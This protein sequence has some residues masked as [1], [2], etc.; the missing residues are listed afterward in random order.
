[1][2]PEQY[3]IKNT[4]KHPTSVIVGGLSRLGMEIA[5]SLIEQ[6]GYVIIVDNFTTGSLDKLGNFPKGTLIS[7]VD[8]QGITSLEDDLRR[9]DYFFYFAHDNS[10]D[11]D[12]VSS[13]YFLNFSNYLD[14][15]LNIV[16]NFES[17]F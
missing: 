14:V 16:A 5:E 3:K 17:K 8:Y 1:M 6:G 9:L 4:V 15:S 2:I 13:Q 7:F 12:K 11:L 10:E